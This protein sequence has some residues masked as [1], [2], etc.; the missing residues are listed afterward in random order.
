MNETDH[1]ELAAAPAA[2]ETVAGSCEHDACAMQPSTPWP[3]WATVIRSPT[4]AS[5]PR[6]VPRAELEVVMLWVADLEQQLAHP[7]TARDHWI[8][9][10]IGTE[11]LRLWRLDRE[12]FR[13]SR[14]KTGDVR[15]S[16]G[17]ARS[18]T[19]L[20]MDLLNRL[21]FKDP[22]GPVAPSIRDLWR[23]T[24]PAGRSGDSARERDRSHVDVPTVASEA[25]S[26]PEGAP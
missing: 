25:H 5:A 4:G 17:E 9:A 10:R 3:S 1:A 24:A 19:R 15:G 23:E 11:Q 2:V 21:T 7:P 18:A 6:H 13:S 14:S 8:L 16:L 22:R 20:I 26:A 12:S